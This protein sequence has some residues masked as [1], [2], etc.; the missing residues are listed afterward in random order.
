MATKSYLSP[1]MVGAGCQE[2]PAAPTPAAWPARRP[3]GG[4]VVTGGGW[5]VTGGGWVV[6]GGGWVVP[7]GAV[8]GG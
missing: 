2:P 4:W 5:V 1:P 8:P 6:T 3:G 7:G